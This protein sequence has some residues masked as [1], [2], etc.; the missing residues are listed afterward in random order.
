MSLTLVGH[1]AWTLHFSVFL[2]PSRTAST[3]LGSLGQPAWRH[4]QTAYRNPILASGSPRKGGPEGSVMGKTN[5]PPIRS[6]LAVFKPCFRT[7]EQPMGPQSYTW[8][9][10]RRW[11]GRSS[12][13]SHARSNSEATLEVRLGFQPHSAASMATSRARQLLPEVDT[14][15]AH[16]YRIQPQLWPFRDPWLGRPRTSRSH[17]A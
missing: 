3:W 7:H 1:E 14:S 17:W 10:H 2:S 12:R 16:P 15:L 9:Q 8:R 4:S 5:V 6:R 13:R 11:G